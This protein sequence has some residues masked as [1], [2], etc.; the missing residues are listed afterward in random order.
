MFPSAKSLFECAISGTYATSAVIP[1]HRPSA[2][3]RLWPARP[4]AI[5]LSDAWGLG[6]DSQG[7]R[8]F[9]GNLLESLTQ[10]GYKRTAGL[11]LTGERPALVDGEER[12]VRAKFR[13][14]RA[15]VIEL[16]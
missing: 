6:C 5:C 15:D 8:A 7:S 12:L 14:H 3:S 1:Q 2:S 4:A 16:F 11:H 10:T 9:S 13:K